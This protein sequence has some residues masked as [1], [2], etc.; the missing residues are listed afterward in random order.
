MHLLYLDLLLHRQQEH[1]CCWC[2][3]NSCLGETADKHDLTVHCKNQSKQ[4]FMKNSATTHSQLIQVHQTPAHR[5][6][7]LVAPPSST[8]E[9]PSAPPAL[10]IASIYVWHSKHAVIFCSRNMQH[11]LNCNTGAA[12]Q[13]HRR[14]WCTAL[15]RPQNSL[16]PTIQPFHII[17]LA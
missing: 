2:C 10:H 11:F 16:L 9:S 15:R 17:L 8:L 12:H 1:L 13:D 4:A 6:H 3:N 7:L 14:I 5:R